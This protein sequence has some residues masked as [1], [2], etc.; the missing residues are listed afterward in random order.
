MWKKCIDFM[1]KH[2]RSTIVGSILV[3]LLGYILVYFSFLG[4][5]VVPTGIGLNKSDWLSFLGTYLSFIGTVAVSVVAMV[6]S[7]YFTQREEIRRKAERHD[8]I[9]PIFSVKIVAIDKQIDGTAEAVHPYKH[10]QA[11][12]KNFKLEIKNVNRFPVKHLIVFDK[13]LT[14]L[15]ESGETIP[16]LC[17]YSD[18]PDIKKWPDKL[19]KILEDD[20]ERT[21]QGLPI[22][23][24]INYEDI[25]GKEMYQ[26]FELKGFEDTSYY[27]LKCTK[28]V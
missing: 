20:F 18:S 17:A 28:E 16:I 14:P 15:L 11:L 4:E 22:D 23:F 10:P 21:E 1:Y 12:H 9:Q 24:C 26:E 8:N 13:Y 3:V 19:I 6:Q 2:K 7:Y 5:G 27:S 25:D